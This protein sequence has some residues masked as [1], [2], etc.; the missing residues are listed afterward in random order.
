MTRTRSARLRISAG[1]LAV[2]STVI[3]ATALAG[4]STASTTARPAYV[5]AIKHV[6]VIN[7]ENKGYDATWGP[8]SAAPY[9]S[10]TLRAKGVLLNSYYGTAHNSEPN[11]VAQISG[12]GPNPQMQGDCQVY[13]QFVQVGTV[14]PG[15][16]VGSGCVFPATVPSL[17]TQLTSIGLRRLPLAL[18]DR[19]GRLVGRLAFGNLARH[20]FGRPELGPLSAIKLRRRIPLIDVGTIAAVKRVAIAVKPAVARLTETGAVFSD[21]SAVDFDAVVLATG[22]RPALAELLAIPGVLDTE[23]YPLDWRGGGVC[24]NLFFVG[25]EGSPALIASRVATRASGILPPALLGSQFADLE[26]LEADERGLRVDVA[27]SPAQIVDLVVAH[28]VAKP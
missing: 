26:P 14:A 7:L 11:Y 28:F 19:I 8:G 24:P 22:F 17:P 10:Q 4:T 18:G 15:Q 3:A 9:L 23:G 1:V 27:L 25:L 2:A 16:A 21:D 6:F 12:Q 13:S 20:G 5:P